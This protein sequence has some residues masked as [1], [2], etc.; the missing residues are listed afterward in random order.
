MCHV[1]PCG[2]ALFCTGDGTGE[3]YRIGGRKGDIGGGGGGAGGS[4]REVCCGTRMIGSRSIRGMSRLSRNRSN[5]DRAPAGGLCERVVSPAALVLVI[6]VESRQ[7]SSSLSRSS[8]WILSLSRRSRERQSPRRGQWIDIL[9]R[10]RGSGWTSN[11]RP[12][13]SIR[14]G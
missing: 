11:D 2:I 13:W 8:F 10:P 4:C 1:A 14:K 6:S 5:R 3:G 9:T 7:V 12:S